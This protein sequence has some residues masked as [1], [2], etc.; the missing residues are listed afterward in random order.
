MNVI[1][2]LRAGAMCVVRGWQAFYGDKKSWRYAVMPFLIMAVF[3]LGIL[4]GVFLLTR[5]AS[6]ALTTY[7]EQWPDWLAWLAY[8]V[9]G[10]LAA[11][12][13]VIV[14]VLAAV[15]VGTVYEFFGGFF[16]DSLTACHERK[17]WGIEPAVMTWRENVKYG[18]ESC[19]F[20]IKTF[21]LFCILFLF[22]LI[23]PVIGPLVLVLG[24]GY[25]FGITYTISAACN[26]RIPIAELKRLCAR[27]RALVIGFGA[28]AYLL[29]MIP[30]FALLLLP[31]L[32]LGGSELLH[33]HL[34]KEA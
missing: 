16:F 2:D 23:V 10:V 6:R 1:K 3:Y 11:G 12:G 27:N 29:L 30:F 18:W 32:V 25:F 21:A 14:L 22:S 8:P 20:G 13:L 19:R 33:A 4:A 5:A 9:N 24:M 34:K 7:I 28:T 31:A 26:S 15:T 17:K